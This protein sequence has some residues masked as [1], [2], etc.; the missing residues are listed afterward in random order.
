MQSINIEF[1]VLDKASA[2]TGTLTSSA[3]GVVTFSS[4]GTINVSG[5]QWSN[6]SF[7]NLEVPLGNF[8]CGSTTDCP[9]VLFDNVVLRA[10]VPVPEPESYAMLLAGLGLMGF[11]ARR[12][13]QKAA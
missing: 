8:I 9:S 6:L 10:T 2:L 11:V 1:I 13:K 5:A 7:V 12:R 3:G 4:V